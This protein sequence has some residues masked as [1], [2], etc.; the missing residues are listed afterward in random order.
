M[1]DK[2]IENRKLS[3]D[4]VVKNF[5]KLCLMGIGLG[6]ISGSLLKTIPKHINNKGLLVKS[7]SKETVNTPKVIY[8]NR[9]RRNISKKE[10][11]EIEALSAKWND[12]AKSQNDLIASG[13]ILFED[14]RY[15][16]FQPNIVLPAA[17]TIKVAILFIAL[18]KLDKG[19]LLWDEL[20]ILN[21]NMIADG[22]GWM[23]YQK[24]GKLFPIH[25]I[26][27]EMI[28][29]S[30]NTAT[31]ILIERIGGLETINR[32]LNELNL[33]ETEIKSLLPDL[34]GTNTTSAKDLSYIIELADKG[35]T[36]TRRSRDIF[37][38][39]MSTSI[40]NTL[41]PDGLLNGLGIN[42]GNSD[43]K[44]LIQGF[45]VYNKTGDIGITYADTA[46]IEMPDTSR[47][48]AAFIVK[49]PFNDQRSTNLIR[50]M[51][52]SIIPYLK[53]KPLTKRP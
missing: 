32:R 14:G 39:V 10:I 31:N 45:R 4:K 1:T 11:Y 52:A 15:A 20:L 29:I 23:R 40:T 6:V 5:L 13:Y 16:Q 18:E 26:A 48:V 27:T 24:I 50:N 21:K 3:A 33:H 30:D 22:S 12:L 47:A 51:S 43:Y 19:E 42:Q 7:S 36:L 28:R 46:L 8:I 49:G 53:P 9:K 38:E 35:N 37:R 34:Q 2:D 25:E 41:I 44:L 17:S